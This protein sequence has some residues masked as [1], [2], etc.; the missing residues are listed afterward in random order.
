[1][2]RVKAKAE[3]RKEAKKAGAAVASLRG[4]RMSA[5]KIRV[6]AD[7]I[8]GLSVDD[9]VTTLAM[10]RRRAAEPLRKVLESAVANADQRDMDIDKFVVSE[11]QINKGAIQR[12][13]MPR[14]HGRATRI[15]KQTAHITIKLSEK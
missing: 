5:R 13:Y 3:A 14:A 2:N 7:V 15:R 6:V 11:V 12:R 10:Q 4:L 8:R 1:M 9:A